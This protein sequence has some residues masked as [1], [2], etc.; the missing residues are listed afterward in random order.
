MSRRRLIQSY[1]TPETVI[2]MIGHRAGSLGYERISTT[3]NRL[4]AEITK[5]VF[6]FPDDHP[7][8][9]LRKAYDSPEF[10]AYCEAHSNTAWIALPRIGAEKAESKAPESH[11]ESGSDLEESDIEETAHV[12][13]A[14]DSDDDSDALAKAIRDAIKSVKPKA[15]PLDE[16]AIR[17]VVKEEC[18]RI[19]FG[20]PTIVEV[21]TVKGEVKNLGAQHK[22]FPQLLAYMSA[23]VP[24]WLAGPAGSGKTTAVE[25]VCKALD[26]PFFHMGAL[27][28]KEDLL[29]FKDAA[30]V[31]H[32]TPFRA[33]WETGG[34][35]CLDECDAY[36]QDAAIALNGALANGHATFPD[37]TS[38][39]M[40]HPDFRVVAC[41]NTWGL[42]A[43]SDYVGRARQDAAFLDRFQFMAWNY[44]ES[45]ERKLAGNPEWTA[46]VQETRRNAQRQ[47]LKVVISPR[48]SILGALLLAHGVPKAQVIATTLRKGMSDDQWNSIKPREA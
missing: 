15:S 40:R 27:A 19:A 8:R 1:T 35:L 32:P 46:L 4:V 26:I 38:P 16:T 44:D 9:A 39:V 14:A 37:S 25:H 43:T 11:E 45:F 29:G 47:G 22:T 12:M 3:Q 2:S 17:R 20:V 10:V 33:A 5:K 48:A 18:E 6:G 42:G 28:Y 34:G 7:F 36:A 13:E 41:G 21:R 24:V 23:G 31:Y 30:G